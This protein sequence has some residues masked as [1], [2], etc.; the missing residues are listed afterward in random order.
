MCL[1]VYACVCAYVCVWCVCVCARMYATL[2]VKKTFEAVRSMA[3]KK[4]RLSS[5]YKFC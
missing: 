5:G 3:S 4:K 2:K 1:C